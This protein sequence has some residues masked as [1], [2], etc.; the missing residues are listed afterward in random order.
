MKR[1][2][3]L[4]LI[5]LLLFLGAWSAPTAASTAQQASWQFGPESTFQYQR[6]DAVFVPGPDGEPWAN[7]VYF[8]GGRTSASTELPDIWM[9]DPITGAYTDTGANMVEDVSNYN[10]SLIVDDGTG[11]G[12]SIYVIGGYDRDRAGANIRTVQRYYPQT[13][14]IDALA[15]ADDWPGT[16][17]GY[18]V[19]GMGAAVVDDVIYIFGGWENI[20]S[21]Y[22]SSET[23]A[24]DPRQPSGSRWTNLG[25]ALSVGRC[26]IEVAA[27][28]GKI[29]AMGGISGYDGSDLM[30][31][32][33]VEVLDTA[34]VA[35]GWTL[36]APLPVATAE[37][38]GFG[39]DS[40]TLGPPAPWSGKL[41]VAGGGDWP[42]GSTQVMEYD[43]AAD[44][45][46]LSFPDLNQWRVNHAGT[47]VPLC[48]DDPNDGLPGMWVFGGRSDNGCDPP[49][50]P[51]EFYP[52]ACAAEPTMHVA[53]IQG[54]F[55]LDPMGR[56]VLLAYVEVESDSLAPLGSVLVTASIWPPEA[57]PFQRTRYTK[58]SGKARF[59][60]GSN[61]AGTWQVCVDD[62][63]LGGYT[64][65]PDDNVVTCGTW[66]N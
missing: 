13:N 44:T 18:A 39:F 28:G 52:M 3:A 65:N 19:A 15:T 10:G 17:A 40:D 46:D 25:Q 61:V 27:Q 5:A 9:F 14:E 26:Y 36:L 56:P 63:Q 60:W 54:R 20:V 50:A 29:Y 66:D 38:R 58:P 7:K 41:Y 12:P 33:A 35:A 51:T 24:F 59:H 11:R 45:W 4:G 16:V 42:D 34:N 64:Y 32:T 6:F 62:L 8:L 47:Y 2:T 22:F 30:P 1:G 37:G 21:P 48:T 23:W 55:S 49:Y 43:V 31:T 57:G 53:G